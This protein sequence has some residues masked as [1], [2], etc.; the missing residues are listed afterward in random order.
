MVGGPLA[1]TDLSFLL[2]LLLTLLG[3]EG[4]RDILENKC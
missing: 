1:S 4:S 2:C 3:V